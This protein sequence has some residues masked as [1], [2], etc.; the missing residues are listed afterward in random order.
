[1]QAL[2]Q[3]LLKMRKIYSLISLFIVI[4]FAVTIFN[5]KNNDPRSEYE[6]FILKKAALQ[7]EV[8]PE[9]SQVTK[10]PDKPG[11]AAFQEYIKTV[12]PELG[13]VP[14]ERL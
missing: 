6:K 13:Y 10:A 8:T 5:Q 7:A 2:D 11:M 14:K 9:L 1:M 3:I 4:V 12:D